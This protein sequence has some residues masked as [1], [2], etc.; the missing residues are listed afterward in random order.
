MGE[1]IPTL[2]EALGLRKVFTIDR[3]DFQTYRIKHGHRYRA[4]ET[5]E[6]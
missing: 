1:R 4:F 6:N 5:L 3:N 2:A